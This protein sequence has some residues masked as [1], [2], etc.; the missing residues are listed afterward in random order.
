MLRRN[1]PLSAS[2][3]D[4]SA[5]GSAGADRPVRILGGWAVRRDVV[6]QVREVGLRAFATVAAGIFAMRAAHALAADPMRFT[7]LLLLISEM[8]TTV[9][10]LLSSVPKHRDWHPIALVCAFWVF[11]YPA[12]IDTAP[13]F[14]LL[15][16]LPAGVV[17]AA[18]LLLTI[19]AK[20]SIGRSFGI[21][22]AR[23]KVVATGPYRFIRHPIYVGYFITSAAFLLSGFNLRNACILAALYGCQFVRVIR[24]E[25]V[26]IEDE[27]YRR[28]CAVV[29]YRFVY[30]LI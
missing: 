9:L 16:Q 27:A 26:L 20:I 2:V 23:R 24:E 18:G 11:G 7:L 25:R 6:A 28:Y 4:L 17:S 22:P 19:C 12:L 15:G 30:G 5:G 10:L 1:L 21:L 14:V 29:P 13:G 3:E 8:L